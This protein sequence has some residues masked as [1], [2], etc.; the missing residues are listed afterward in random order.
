MKKLQLIAELAF[1]V[2]FPLI[3]VF[4]LGWSI[5]DI[6]LLFFLE[7]LIRGG[8]TILKIL[9]ST[10]NKLFSRLGNVF[11]FILIFSVLFIFMLILT[12]HYFSGADKQMYTSLTKNT[13]LILAGSYILTS[14]FPFFIS[15]DFRK[16]TPKAIINRGMKFEFLLFICVLITL[17]ACS[18]LTSFVNINYILATGIIVGKNM[19]SLFIEKLLNPA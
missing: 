8:I 2:A 7:I 10:T 6:F 15:G 1:N 4:Y 18:I 16:Q 17:F 14:L 9:S 5:G 3:G 11:Y 19:A 12:G 13:V